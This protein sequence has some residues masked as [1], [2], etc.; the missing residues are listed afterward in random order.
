[1]SVIN[2]QLDALSPRDR[3]LL[4]GMLVVLGVLIVGVVFFAMNRSLSS[5]AETIS[6]KKQALALI[7]AYHTRHEVAEAR[8]A[9]AEETLREFG[10]QPA[11]AFL[12]RAATS[13]EVREQF[14]V[15]KQG[16]EIDGNL[17]R[18]R[19]KVELNRVPIVLAHNYI[20]D[21]EVSDYPMQIESAAWRIQ[22]RGDERL[23]Q[24]TLELVTFALEE[25]AG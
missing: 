22:K 21:I 3:K 14:T 16:T 23:A 13:V 1:M 20:Y 9:A 24:V 4:A 8:I 7:Q 25:E 15:T 11:S 17:A 18:T 10:D 19:Y 2:D 6:D 5:K 12:E